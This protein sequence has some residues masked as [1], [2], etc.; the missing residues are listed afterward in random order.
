MFTSQYLRTNFTGTGTDYRN[1]GIMAKLATP[2]T[3]ILKIINNLK[4]GYLE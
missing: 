3:V 1:F 4:S 2:I